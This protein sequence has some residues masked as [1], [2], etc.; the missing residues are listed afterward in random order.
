[1]RYFKNPLKGQFVHQICEEHPTVCHGAIAV[2]ARHRQ[3]AE[4]PTKQI[5]D[6]ENP[7][8]LTHSAKVTTCL[9]A[10]LVRE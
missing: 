3:F 10:N 4:V 9:R 2:G 6:R 1:M 5:E 7:L 8:A